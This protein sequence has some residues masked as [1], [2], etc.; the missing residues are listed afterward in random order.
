MNKDIT[1]VIE[2]LGLFPIVPISGYINR[3]Y[4]AWSE[5]ENWI[6]DIKTLNELLDG[7]I[8][9]K[10]TCK[11]KIT[12]DKKVITY[13][14]KNITG[15]GL[16][17]GVRSDIIV[18]D[19]DIG[20]QEGVNGVE[21][22]NKYLEKNNIPNTV[23]NTFT[24]QTSGGGK[25]L[26]YRYNKD[27]KGT[28]GILKG[29]DIRA[30]GNQVPVPYTIRKVTKGNEEA[31]KQYTI[32]NNVPI[33]ELPKELEALV[34][35][36]NNS[37]NNTK[38]STNNGKL[39]LVEIWNNGIPDGT[40][41]DMMLKVAGRIRRNFNNIEDFAICMFALNNSMCVPP[42]DNDELDNICDYVWNKH[43]N[44]S[45][46][47][48]PY[49]Y[50]YDEKKCAIF[51]KDDTKDDEEGEN[52]PATLVYKGYLNLVGRRINIDTDEKGYVIESKDLQDYNKLILS[53]EELFGSNAERDIKNIFA[54][55]KGFV[56]LPVRQGSSKPV[57]KLL[58][59][60]DI[61]KRKNNLMVDTYYTNNIGWV[62]YNNTK[63]FSYP[64][65]ENIL[66]TVECN[67][68]GNTVSNSFTISGTAQDWIDNVMPL[69][70]SSNNG[71]VM[72][73][74]SFG[75]PLVNLLDI[76]ENSILQLEGATSTGKTHCLQGCASVYGNDKYIKQ[77]NGT[78]YAINTIFSSY[79][80]FP[81]IFDDLKNIN[82][83]VKNE[84][85]NICYGFVQ[86]E[87]KLQGKSDG[88]LRKTF[89]FS[90]LL[91]TSSEY[92]ITDD[93]KQHEGA[94]ARVLVLP[95]SFLPVNETNREIV[96]KLD[97][98]S[99]KYYGTI[100]LDWCKY[101]IDIKNNNKVE[102]YKE[103]YE[104]Y[105]EILQSSTTN[106]ILSRKCNTIAL[107]QVTGYLL[108]D[109]LGRDYFNMDKCINELMAQIEKTTK[110]ADINT[111]AFLD[112]VEQ[113]KLK[114]TDEN[115]IYY[116]STCIGSYRYNYTYDNKQYGEVLIVQGTILKGIIEDLDYNASTTIRAW[117]DKG[118]TVKD[119]KNRNSVQ[120]KINGKN[121]RTTVLV[122]SYYKELTNSGADL[123]LVPKN[124]TA[125]D[126]F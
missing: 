55:T 86:G 65:K 57:L 115:D 121:V 36:T 85:G 19:L 61:H 69:L 109:F 92:A 90:S 33:M 88:G 94:T 106:N 20:H 99:R 16:L 21:T 12:N 97:T 105:R 39:D 48:Y 25:H 32:I 95:G 14:N 3:P 6:T 50:Y 82:S 114:V 112:V 17:T 40:R 67:M 70:L 34:T 119:N 49:P 79:G 77:W 31:L 117:G 42:L 102:E 84:L 104:T 122:L 62:K 26:Y 120:N 87:S 27:L 9:Y 8:T 37:S 71:K 89:N 1:K 22:F 108:E 98:N 45:S 15:F 43:I 52:T 75:A 4:V 96:N 68:E 124:R 113:L 24:V 73:L 2:K 10:G 23:T 35:T 46:N 66:D 101:L 126:V 58:Y 111:N 5:Q 63:L 100:G 44:N 60:Q 41:N 72:L 13:T 80:S 56:N 110:E 83:K 123:T 103:L 91:L 18:I 64:S 29:V 93:L 7:K 118:Y 28:V 38:N 51:K 107:L 54:R 74:G 116:K 76:H 125:T 53:G 78:P 59:E 30:N 11:D 47:N 81:I